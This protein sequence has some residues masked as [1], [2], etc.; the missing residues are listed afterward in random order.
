MGEKGV[1]NSIREGFVEELE[2]VKFVFFSLLDR[3]CLGRRGC[4][5]G[6]VFSMFFFGVINSIW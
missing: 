4:R 3:G 1:G 5:R 2:E 6:G